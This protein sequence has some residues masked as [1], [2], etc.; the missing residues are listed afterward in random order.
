LD[1]AGLPIDDVAAPRRHFYS[2]EA[3]SGAVVGYGGFEIYE[4]AVLLRSIVVLPHFRG[5]GSGRRAVDTLIEIA[6]EKGARTAYLLTTSA[7]GFFETLGFSRIERDEAPSSIL[8]SEQARKLCPGSAALFRR[9]LEIWPSE[10]EL[11]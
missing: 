4:E 3:P 10:R 7:M 6:R 11:Q 2:F 5:R 1:S 9:N 8:N